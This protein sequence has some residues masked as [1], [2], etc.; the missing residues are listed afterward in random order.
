MQAKDTAP[1]AANTRDAL[2]L[3]EVEQALAAAAIQEEQQSEALVAEALK[4]AL[5]AQQALEKQIAENAQLKRVSQQKCATLSDRLA[6]AEADRKPRA[7]IVET[8]VQAIAQLQ[9]ELRAARAEIAKRDAQQ[10]AKTK[11]LKA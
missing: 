5:F 9:A 7:L 1:R 2:M 8:Q 11:L 10:A 6:A 3:H 4:T